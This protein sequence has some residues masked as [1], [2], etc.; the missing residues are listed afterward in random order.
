MSA[1]SAWPEAD[2]LKAA[3]VGTGDHQM[4]QHPHVRQRQLQRQ[5]QRLRQVLVG[6][7]RLD[8]TR[9]VVVRQYDSG[10]V[11]GQR[12]LDHLA[13]THRGLRHRATEHLLQLDDAMLR[14]QEQHAEHLVLQ[15]ADL[16]QQ[17]ILYRLR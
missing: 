9:G 5:L 6:A 13:G 4:I 16:Q 12:G 1:T 2:V 8:R 14:I 10:G 3:H 17:V 15:H 7:A 11:A